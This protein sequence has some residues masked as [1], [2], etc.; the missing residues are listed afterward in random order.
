MTSIAAIRTTFRLF[1]GA[2]VPAL[3]VL[4]ML[5]APVNCTCGSS[6]PHGHSLFQLAH[7]HHGDDHDEHSD[8]AEHEEHD[9]GRFAH[10]PH[11]AMIDEPECDSPPDKFE[12]SGNFALSNAMEQQDSVAMQSAPSTSFAHPLAIA[13]PSAIDTPSSQECDSVFLPA[14]RTLEGV[15]TSPETPPPRA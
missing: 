10:L 6:I 12:F 8:H 14:T 4:G 11:P 3:M 5:M 15:A 1:Y 2:I 9:A 7:H 13:Q